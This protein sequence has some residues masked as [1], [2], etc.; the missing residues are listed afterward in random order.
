M[1][2]ILCP[3][4]QAANRHPSE[5]ALITPDRIITYEQYDRL[6]SA[7]ASNFHNGGVK[8]GERV[9]VV[10]ENNLQYVIILMALFRLK[11][12]ACLISPRFTE[13]TISDY[14]ER[15]E[16]DCLI[17]QLDTLRYD[18]SLP[19]RKLAFAD[20]V[21]LGGLSKSLT[22][23]LSILLQQDA[24]IIYTSG[25][26]AQPK[27]VLH[28]Y[29][30]HYYNALGSNKNINVQPGDRWLL[31]LPLYHVGGLAILFR[32]MLG[33]GTVVIPNDSADILD[34]I[35]RHN[36]TH[37]SL[38]STQLYRL[39]K[40]PSFNQPACQLKAVLV[41]G[42]AVPKTLIA[43]AYES[44]LPLFTTYGLTEMAS[45]V[46][47]TQPADSLDGV[48]TSGKSLAYGQIKISSQGEIMVKGETL[49]C[50]YV[51]KTDV[52]LPVD[53]N[54]WFHTGDL[55]VIDS[56]GYLTVAG[57]K[58]NMFISGGENIHPEEIEGTLSLLDGISEAVVVPVADDEYGFRPVA[59]VRIA[60]NNQ[61]SKSELIDCL[62]KQLP[63]YKFPVRFYLW[64]ESKEKQQM[65]PDRD[66]IKELLKRGVLTEIT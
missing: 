1:S 40:T 42:S 31:S 10:A 39:L 21:A 29:G 44:G 63:H 16:C 35:Q 59:F 8:A 25:T 62:K 49:F 17:Y 9:A 22:K 50:G 33:G 47:A 23:D 30:N 18:N 46:T 14:L 19:I 6:V 5:P 28:S 41:G 15:I 57:R 60:N 54:G 12:V 36:V 13:K 45:Q 37:L 56:D 65:K 43:K 48:L 66:Y 38:V 51:D 58:D 7:A 64:P 20:V 4:A 32:A 24:T 61:V 34:A 27:A 53:N 26:T 3:L 11:A 2:D 52:T 55:G